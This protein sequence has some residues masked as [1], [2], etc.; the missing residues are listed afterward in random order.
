M[1]NSDKGSNI[2]KRATRPVKGLCAVSLLGKEKSLCLTL[3]LR[4]LQVRTRGWT[5]YRA[6]VAEFLC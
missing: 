6:P 3:Q 1:M 2:E 4:L 5:P